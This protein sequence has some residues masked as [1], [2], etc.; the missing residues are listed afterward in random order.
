[1]AP[2]VRVFVSLSPPFLS[3]SLRTVALPRRR[4]HRHRR[5]LILR[6]HDFY[7]AYHHEKVGSGSSVTRIALQFTSRVAVGYVRTGRDMG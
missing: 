5:R 4:C 1:M 7:E 3:L 2:Y 6:R